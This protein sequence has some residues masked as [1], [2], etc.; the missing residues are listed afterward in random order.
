MPY[1]IYVQQDVVDISTRHFE[2]LIL[3]ERTVL[4]FLNGERIRMMDDVSSHVYL[5]K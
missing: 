2:Y 4:N 3:V 1:I 5:Y